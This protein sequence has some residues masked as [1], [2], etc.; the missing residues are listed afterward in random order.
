MY[1]ESLL[2]STLSREF[3]I[4]LQYFLSYQRPW[5]SFQ[6]QLSVVVRES[7]CPWCDSQ[8][9]RIAISLQDLIN[10][11]TLSGCV[12]HHILDD[13]Y[14]LFYFCSC[15]CLDVTCP[16]FRASKPSPLRSFPSMFSN[17]CYWHTMTSYI[18]WIFGSIYTLPHDSFFS[19]ILSARF[20]TNFL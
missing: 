6:F 17:L 2:V 13:S 5:L 4:S 15:F 18:H 20:F 12:G 3:R 9:L 14:F 16:I 10:D 8:E 1:I 19:R 11:V 7:L